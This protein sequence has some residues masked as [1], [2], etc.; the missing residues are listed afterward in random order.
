MQEGVEVTTEVA[1]VVAAFIFG[2]L[3]ANDFAATS[4]E[5]TNGI[6]KLYLTTGAGLRLC[7]GVEDFRREDVSR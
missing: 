6:G 2:Q 3:H 4:E 7:D 1:D 5:Q